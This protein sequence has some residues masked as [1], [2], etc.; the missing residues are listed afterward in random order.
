MATTARNSIEQLVGRSAEIDIVCNAIASARDGRGAV[1]LFAGEPGIGKSTLARFGARMASEQGMAVYWG[2]SWEAGGAPA[3]WPWTQLLRSLISDE[4]IDDKRL[5]PLVQILPELAV[6]DSSEPELQPDQARFLLLESVRGLLASLAAETPLVLILEDLH[7]ADSDSLH[8]LQ[9]LARHAA[10]L[11]LLI[12]GTYRD[13]EARS[14]AHT[15]PLWRTSRDATVLRLP[16]LEESDIR[17]YL[18]LRDGEKPDD[19]AVH[20]LLQTTAGNPLFLTELVGLLARDGDAASLE[21]QL[22]DSVQQV[23]RQQL[24]LL[25]PAATSLLASASVFGREFSA[26][27][28]ATMV[29]QSESEILQ[30][31]QPT[32]DAEIIRAPRDGRF[33]FGHTLYRD[34][35]Y[36][37]LGAS[38]RAEAHLNCAQRLQR[39]I[40]EGDVDRWSALARHLQLAGPEHRLAAIDALRQAAARAHARLAFEDAATL[41]LQAVAAFGEGPKYDPLDRCRLLVD[42]GSALLVTGEI[43]AGQKH[44]QDAFAIAR[45]IGDAVLMSEVA[46]T[47]GSII[48]VAKVDQALI[49]ALEGCLAALPLDDATMRSR[50]QARLAGAMQPALNPAVP[51]DMAREAVALARTTGDKQV[52][53]SVLRFALAALMDFAPPRER[54]KL[55]REFASMAAALDDVPQ[56]FRSNLLLMIDASEVGDRVTLDEAVQACDDLANRIGLPHYQWRAASARAMQATI[57]G[58]FERASELL[59]VAQSLADEVEDLQ[60]IATPALQRF[61]LLVEWDSPRATPLEDI[62]A[63]LQRAYTGGIGEAEFYVAPFIAIY[64]EGSDAAFAKRFIANDRLVERTFAGGDRYSL[65]GLGQMALNAGDTVLA[66]RCYDVLVNYRDA[67]AT[68]GLLGTCWCGPVAYWLGKL[69]HG[70]G[71]LQEAREHADTAL[72]IATRMRARP[73]IARIHASAADIAR[74]AGDEARAIEHSNEATGL[75][76]ALGMRPVRMAPTAKSRPAPVTPTTGLSM[77]QDGDIWTVEY[78][79]QSATVRDAKGLHMLAELIARPDTNI[80]VLDLS[81]TPA[82]AESGDSGPMLDTQARD[83]YRNRVT[84]LQ[85]ELEEAESLADLGRADSLRS[86]IDFI[87]RELSRAFGLGGRKRTTGDA[88]ERARVNVRRRI[89]DAVERIG[90]QSPDAG[91]YLENTIKTGRYCKYSPM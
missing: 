54:I 76:K 77:R 32:I 59:D 23:I 82:A 17:D 44:C 89:K 13:V 84:E 16:R 7:A 91:R 75:M 69:A 36:Q 2:F 55:N 29:G 42:C 72:D 26:P 49:A 60:A 5:A 41:L 39:L 67:C 40:D 28:L 88:A 50:I 64:K 6:A 11:P 20:R 51:M 61:A 3:Y 80:H 21:K 45:T 52:L 8:L 19:T 85:E 15:E 43:E 37:D 18:Q 65:T 56:L 81:G 66:S 90:E 63:Q 4:A 9:Y 24:A 1:L 62:E 57:D 38:R 78:G 87:V 30:N 34:V 73:Y 31:L 10:S 83:E 22:P 79:G 12:I 70:L 47:W 58:D 33:R 48:M 68:L 25:P 71:R 74:D 14:S 86:E 46:L 53:Y 27:E 35:L